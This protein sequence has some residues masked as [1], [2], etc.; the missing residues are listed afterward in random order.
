MS[1]TEEVVGQITINFTAKG[2]PKVTIKGFINPRLVPGLTRAIQVAYRQYMHSLARG[3]KRV[4]MSDKGKKQEGSQEA[5]PEAS[6]TGNI[7]EVP[8]PEAPAPKEELVIEDDLSEETAEE[9]AEEVVE[10]SDENKDASPASQ[11]SDQ[12]KVD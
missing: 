5:V 8:T 4:D 3:K 10:V 12:Y 7:F 11:V 2:R 6:A 1:E 9:T